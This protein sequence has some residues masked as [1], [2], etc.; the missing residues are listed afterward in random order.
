MRI[1]TD[2]HQGSPSYDAL[3]NVESEQPGAYSAFRCQRFDHKPVKYKMLS[4]LL[5]LRMEQ[6]DEPAG[7]RIERTDIAAFPSVA[8]QT[9]I[10]EVILC[11]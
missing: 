2:E 5:P 1:A 11:G 7:S 10:S 9:S 6:G 4:P 3:I 8:T